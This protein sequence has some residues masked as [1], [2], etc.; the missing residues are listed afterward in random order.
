MESEIANRAVHR[1]RAGTIA[2]EIPQPGAVRSVDVQIDPVV[3]DRPPIKFERIG[4]LIEINRPCC[5]SDI[6]IL[7]KA[8]G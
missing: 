4:D 3:I 7:Y 1:L 5:G 6:I 2:A 8:V